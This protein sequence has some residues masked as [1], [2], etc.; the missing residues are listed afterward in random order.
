[1]GYSKVGSRTDFWPDNT[2]T[3]LYLECDTI[4]D[5][6]TLLGRAQEYFG[7]NMD[8]A[9]ASSN[10]KIK[11]E[12]IHTGAIYYDL[13]DPSDHTLFYHISLNVQ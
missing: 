3:D 2:E 12:N 10:F 5:I 1:M 8:T 6:P 13:H 7:E 11:V 4:H 9:F